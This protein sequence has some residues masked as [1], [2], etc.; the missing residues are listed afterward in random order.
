MS[1]HRDC[2]PVG[3]K[4]PRR[5]ELIIDAIVVDELCVD[6]SN[7]LQ[8]IS[9]ISWWSQAILSV[10]DTVILYCAHNVLRYSK[11]SDGTAGLI[12]AASGLAVSF[13][14]MFWTWRG[15]RLGKR[16]VQKDL[17]RITAA[18]MI[19]RSIK[20]GV[21]VNV[22]GIALALVGA[23]QIVGSLTIKAL[24]QPGG[25]GG[26][27][28]FGRRRGIRLQPL[29]ILV[30]QGNANTILSHVCSLVAYM[31][32]SKLVKRLDPPSVDGEEQTQK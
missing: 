14:S 6:A 28:R 1:D 25:L 8:R 12:I 9:W 22:L 11:W 19:R 29:D 31:C 16:L 20:V 15:V 7:M 13:V 18:N 26:K 27:G 32:I 24:T 30:V 21:I 2:A 4:K 5:D 3:I 17:A 10:V 23:E